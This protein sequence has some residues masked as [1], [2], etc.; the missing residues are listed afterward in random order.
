[1]KGA[2]IVSTAW[3][4]FGRS[5]APVATH[6]FRGS[7]EKSAELLRERTPTQTF[8][9]LRITRFKS[10]YEARAELE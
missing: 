10:V 1:M 9:V 3:G 8:R 7:A 2:P 4:V 5:V 6:E